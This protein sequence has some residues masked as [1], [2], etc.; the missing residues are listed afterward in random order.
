MDIISWDGS[1][2]DLTDLAAADRL[3]KMKETHSVWA[4]IEEIIKIWTSKHPT[5]WQSYLVELRDL[6]GSRA[7]RTYGRSNETLKHRG[8]RGSLRVILDIPFPIVAMIR[9]L[10]TT[11]ELPMD[12]GFNR[13]FA[14]KFPLFRVAEKI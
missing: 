3:I 1:T 4:V 8:D 6:K 10:Y 5:R 2:H 9:K 7:D 13:T 12:M 11:E 14:R